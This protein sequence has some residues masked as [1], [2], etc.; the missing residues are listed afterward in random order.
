MRPAK[1]LRRGVLSAFT[2][3]NHQLESRIAQLDRLTGGGIARGRI[4]EITGALSTGRTS[5]AA[6]FAA[7]ATARHEIVGWID[8]ASTLDPASLHAAGVDP[9]RL[10]WVAVNHRKWPQSQAQAEFS[11]GH[12]KPLLKAA[13]LVLDA[14]GFGLA[15][16]DFGSLRYPL[17]P[18]A[19]LRLAR[20]AERSGTAVLALA[21]RRM[22][23]TCASLSLALKRA[24]TLF[25]RL[26]AGAPA[27]FD[28]LEL[29]ASVAYSKFGGAG[30]RAIIRA[31]TNPAACDELPWA[32]SVWAASGVAVQ[33]A[34]AQG[35]GF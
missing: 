7:A 29:E 23:G 14:G 13:E 12:C 16:I 28:G 11:S 19:A 32:A 17:L 33:P 27:I 4:S 2:Q 15:V 5:L 1:N 35:N 6:A 26:A 34:L 8:G 30:G 31:M 22:C 3:R 25:G 20:A 18:G 9:A 24:D 10:L 21:G